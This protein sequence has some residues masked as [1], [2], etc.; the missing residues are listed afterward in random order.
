[1][2]ATG[3]T[4]HLLTIITPRGTA[5]GGRWYT[6]G[7]VAT[8]SV[9]DTVTVNGTVYRFTGWSGDSTDASSAVFVTMDGPKT[10]SATWTVVPQGPP[11][12]AALDVLPWI[13]LAILVAVVGFLIFFV[14]GRRR[15]KGDEVS[16]PPPPSGS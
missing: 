2:T 13:V 11:S 7:R 9:P 12:S 4:E 8:A 5:E 3:R 1:V 10:L 6:E 15:R 16:R 14:L